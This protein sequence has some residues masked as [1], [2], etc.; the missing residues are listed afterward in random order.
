MKVCGPR[1]NGTRSYKHN[2]TTPPTIT[3]L[4]RADVAH[5]TLWPWQ[6]ALIKRV[7]H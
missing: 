4:S 7:D 2:A 1:A 3:E 5:E 6:P